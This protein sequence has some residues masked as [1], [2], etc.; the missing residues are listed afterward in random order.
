[1]P[2]RYDIAVVGAGIVGLATA[3][4]LHER[5]PDLRL[6]VLDKEP[7][8]GAHQTGHNSGVL[9]SAISYAPGSLKA[10]LAREGKSALERFCDEHGVP[11][12]R[13][14]KVVVAT[15]PSEVVRLDGL[16]ERGRANG[17]EGLRV[18]GPDELR[19]LEPHVRAV[20]ALHVPGTGVVDMRRVA[21]VLAEVL[22]GTGV[23]LL[24]G[25]RVEAI[26][27]AP[28]E[29]VVLSTDGGEVRARFVVTCGGL[30]S[31]RLAALSGDLDDT[32]IVPF[33]GDYAVLRPHARGLVRALVY[34][35]ADPA[36]PFLGVHATRRLDGEVWLGPNAVLAF[37][38]ER[39][40]RLAVERDDARDVLRFPG[41]W[42]VVRRW[43][44]VGFEEQWRD[45]SKR[46]FV[47][48]ARRLLPDLRPADVAWGPV[49]V[50]AQL[51]GRDGTL[52][53]DFVVA[54]S[55]RM[56]HVRNAPSPGGTASL[57]IGE[58]VATRALAGLDDA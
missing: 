31:D 58:E 34:P 24:L 30:Q 3:F 12:E 6:A 53:D 11:Y 37:A 54:G 8:V 1:M 35:V 29:D 43:W 28:G 16:L 9:H 42:R 10:R 57:A 55:E 45:V 47:A 7:V 25:R 20:R 13:C 18:I 41:T 4:R 26:A 52:V 14:G 22:R 15:R 51:V 38:R 5:R 23:D 2:E 33:R 32:R 49:G 17:V 46:A 39:Y 27:R 44:R 21:E 40:R 48:A 56:I 36:L 50:R 19:E